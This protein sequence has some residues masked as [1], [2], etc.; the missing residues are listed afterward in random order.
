MILDDPG[1][2]E[3]DYQRSE[4]SMEY[5]EWEAKPDGAIEFIKSISASQGKDI[6]I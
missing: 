6:A 2:A 3:E 5:D 4:K 1:M